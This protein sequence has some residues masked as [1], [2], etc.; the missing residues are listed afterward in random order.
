MSKHAK[1]KFRCVDGPFKDTVIWLSSDAKSAVFAV[2]GLVGRYV[3][4]ACGR[5][6]WEAT[7]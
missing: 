7:E 3:G 2:R 5:A 4:T 1:R 6:I